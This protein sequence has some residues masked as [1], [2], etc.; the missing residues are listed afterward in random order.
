MH[1]ALCGAS[2]M[3]QPHKPT[4]VEAGDH[5]AVAVF[6]GIPLLHTGEMPLQLAVKVLPAALAQSQPH[7]ETDDAANPRLRAVIQYGGDILLRVVDKRQDGGEPDDC[8]YPGFA[9]LFERLKA[10]LRSAYVRLD[11]PAK[12][13]VAGGERH[14]H[15]TLA[16]FVYLLQQIQVTQQTGR[17]GDDG[18]AKAVPADQGERAPDVSCLHLQ[19]DIGIRHG[20]GPDHTFLPPAPERRLKQLYGVLLDLDILKIMLHA[21]TAA[22]RIAVYTAVRAAAV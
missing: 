10:F 5:I 19:R 2:I 13:L 11:F 21:V 3:K 22:A 20:A 17:L 9:Q 14:L 18:K 16:P 6:I 7:T 4:V 8:W 12:L 1:D 15:H